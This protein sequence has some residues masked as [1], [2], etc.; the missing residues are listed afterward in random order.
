MIFPD[1]QMS[2]PRIDARQAEAVEQQTRGRA[3]LA[4]NLIEFDPRAERSMRHL[5]GGTFVCEDS[6]VAK[7]VA[8]DTYKFRCVTQEGDVF[9]PSGM[10]SGGA[11]DGRPSFI[12]KFMRFRS[13]Q[14]EI[15]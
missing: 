13:A 3:K 12:D 15:S 2:I 5:F 7:Q 4:L 9:D 14:E 10:L 6:N 8:F 1:S 11:D